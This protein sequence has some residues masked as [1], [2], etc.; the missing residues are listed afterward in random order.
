MGRR[1]NKAIVEAAAIPAQRGDVFGFQPH[2]VGTANDAIGLLAPGPGK[3]TVAYH[4][5][6]MPIVQASAAVT[7][8]LGQRELTLSASSHVPLSAL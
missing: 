3:G 8:A 6:A 1:Y 7:A 4:R 5:L 2:A